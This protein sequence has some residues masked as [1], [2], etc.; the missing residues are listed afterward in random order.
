M[1]PGE[2][3]TLL[4][5]AACP[6]ADRCVQ[7]APKFRRAVN[8]LMY[9]VDYAYH[10]STSEMSRQGEGVDYATLLLDDPPLLQRWQNAFDYARLLRQAFAAVP[11]ADQRA[12]RES[13]LDDVAYHQARVAS[14]SMNLERYK[15]CHS[16]R[17]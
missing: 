12:I 8:I 15:V 5:S 1:R 14:G 17:F 6:S 10:K 9:L 13:K 11:A 16:F 3:T 4:L 7:I 2:F